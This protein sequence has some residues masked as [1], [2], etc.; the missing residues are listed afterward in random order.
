MTRSEKRLLWGL[1]LLML[2][3]SLLEASV[4]GSVDWSPSFSREHSK[5]YGS[6]LVYERLRDLFPEVRSVSGPL[7]EVHLQD[8]PDGAVNRI[9]LNAWIR[10]DV[11]ETEHLLWL[12][13]QGDRVLIAA[14]N[15]SGPLADSLGVE[16]DLRMTGPLVDTIDIRFVG[17]PR[18][19][20]GTFR[21]ARGFRPNYFS[22]Y[23]KE[24]SRVLAVDGAAKPVLLEVSHG[25]GRF[26]LCSTPL[27]ITNH[28]LLK[29]N[30][31][32]YLA[33]VLSVLPP[34][35][36]VWDEQHKVARA[37]ASTPLRWLLSQSA[38]RWA[39]FLGLGLLVLHILVHVRRQ[40]RAIPVVQAPRNATRELV[41][42]MGRLHWY[43]GDHADL[44][45][46][47]IA[48][49]KEEVRQA[50]YLRTFGYDN[51]TTSHLAAK[52]GLDRAEVA[53]RLHTLERIEHTAHLS[54]HE[55]LKLSNE[56]H[57]FSQLIRPHGTATP[58]R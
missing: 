6:K 12:V 20:Q 54:E 47:M 44:A 14:E 17:D 52:T 37:E 33:G 2:V 58:S 35:P 28:N 9:F 51:A 34:W 49:F 13:E 38:L 50:T 41:H 45:R 10:P 24:R 26:V 15:L 39:W 29:A 42:T 48:H 27:A 36:V 53:Q 7:E 18:I 43:K 1:G 16:M 3:L 5:P 57:A 19:A 40:Q 46:R 4:P 23:D 11:V 22:A 56:L 31:G 32:T 25:A 8:H 21:Y 30:N 55:L